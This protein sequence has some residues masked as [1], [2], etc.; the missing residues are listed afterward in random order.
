[1]FLLL[2]TALFLISLPSGGVVENILIS[3]LVVL[4]IEGVIHPQVEI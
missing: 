3:P 1:L 2:E 4:F